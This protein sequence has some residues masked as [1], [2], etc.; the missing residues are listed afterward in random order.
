MMKRTFRSLI[1][2]ALLCVM[3]APAWAVKTP[4]TVGRTTAD[5][6]II[7]VRNVCHT[8]GTTNCTMFA[9]EVVEWVPG[10]TNPGVDV[11]KSTTNDSPLVAGVIVGPASAVTS[12][13]G[14]VASGELAAMIL[15][16]A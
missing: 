13:S 12:K 7:N 6:I 4:S 1:V 14:T 9:G 16:N 15:E 2:L 10:A 11:Q 8:A 5:W 3:V